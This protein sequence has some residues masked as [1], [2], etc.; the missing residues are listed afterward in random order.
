MKNLSLFSIIALTTTLAYAQEPAT[1]VQD[2]TKAVPA[3][4][5]KA[6]P[7]TLAEGTPIGGSIHG[8]IKAE[9]SPYL[10]TE[11]LTVE[12]NQV[13]VIVPGVKLQFAPG[14]GL[15]VKGQLVVAGTVEFVSASS[16]PQN[17]DWKGIF[18]TGTES[19]EIII[20]HTR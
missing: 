7:A 2:T 11:D 4:S 20:I 8:F 6:A 12:A 13:L 17:G 14:T 10:V 3:E 18:L 16:V 5:P 9:Q 15:Y 19:S 1:P